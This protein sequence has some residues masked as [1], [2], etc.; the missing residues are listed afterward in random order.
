MPRPGSPKESAC[1]LT[2]GAH[3][4]LR[5]S[6]IVQAGQALAPKRERIDRAFKIVVGPAIAFRDGIPS[7]FSRRNECTRF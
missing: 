7:N 3:T 6:A 5:A 1:R 4:S 2:L